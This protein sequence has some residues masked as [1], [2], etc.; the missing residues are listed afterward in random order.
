MKVAG[1]SAR[2]MRDAEFSVKDL[3][4]GGYTAKEVKDSDHCADVLCEARPESL[5]NDTVDGESI[6]DPLAADGDDVL[7]DDQMLGMPCESPIK[8]SCRNGEYLD[9]F[10]V[11]GATSNRSPDAAGFDCV[12]GKGEMEAEVVAGEDDM[13]N[14]ELRELRR[15]EQQVAHEEKRQECTFFFLDAEFVRRTSAKSLPAYS[16]LKKQN[17]LVRRTLNQPEAYRAQYTKEFVAVSHRWGSREEPDPGGDQLQALKTYLR[18]DF[19]SDIK[20]VWFDFSSMPQRED[21]TPSEDLVAQWMLQNA[22]L[23]FLGGSVLLLV[24]TAFLTRFWTQFEAWLS[25]QRGSMKGLSPARA[26][27]N[28]L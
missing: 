25:L 17:V 3:K 15:A 27:A 2:E 14:D 12:S 13:Q 18:T 19:G 20:L 5:A 26:E 9:V 28:P 16:E 10:L 24:D 23:L 7:H 1:F 8:G 4:D 21:R 6:P 22:S 11:D